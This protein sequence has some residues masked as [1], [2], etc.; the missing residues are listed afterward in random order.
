LGD[1]ITLVEVVNGLVRPHEANRSHDSGWDLARQVETITTPIR[2]NGLPV[3]FQLASAAGAH[4]AVARLGNAIVTVEGIG[5]IGVVALRTV[6]HIER[7]IDD[8]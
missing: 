1:V 7:Y 2:V 8:H 4:A 5:A 6:T 3:E